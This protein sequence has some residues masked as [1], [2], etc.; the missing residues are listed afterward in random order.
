MEILT[1]KYSQNH[2]SSYY[3]LAKQSAMVI[4]FVLLLFNCCTFISKHHY[5]IRGLILH[6][7]MWQSGA[8]SPLKLV[9][10]GP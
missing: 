7:G 1:W 3:H 6:S 9:M 5:I 2:L 10:L 8:S 4:E